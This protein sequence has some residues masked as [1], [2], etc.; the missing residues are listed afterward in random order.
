MQ[1]WLVDGRRDDPVGIGCLPH[2]RSCFTFRV[3]GRE[4][5][6]SSREVGKLPR[7]DLQP[8]DESGAEDEPSAGKEHRQDEGKL[9][10]CLAGF[11]ARLTHR[12]RFVR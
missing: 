5:C 11:M 8:S 7:L 3:V 9:D 1:E 6:A 12:V 2:H 4:R 10:R